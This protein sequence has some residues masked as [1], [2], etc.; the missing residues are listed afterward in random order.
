MKSSIDQVRVGEEIGG[1]VDDVV[2][3]GCVDEE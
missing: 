2:G 1:A 3:R